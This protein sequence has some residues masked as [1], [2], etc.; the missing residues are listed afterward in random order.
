MAS[1]EGE[2][3]RVRRTGLVMVVAVEWRVESVSDCTSLGE[4]GNREGSGFYRRLA[5]GTKIKKST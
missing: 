3:R 1:M 4:W 2:S 5:R